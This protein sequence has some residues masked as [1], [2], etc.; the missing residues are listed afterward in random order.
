M[1][2]EKYDRVIA[3]AGNPNVGKSSLFNELTGLRQ[4]TG[5]WTGKTVDTAFGECKREGKCYKIIDLPG[6]Y[7]LFS[8]SPEEE[9]TRRYIMSGEAELC[10]VVCDASSL[11]AGLPLVLQMSEVYDKLIVVLNL[12]DETEKYSVAIDVER[13]SEIL[14]CPVVTT[15]AKRKEGIDELISR[16]EEDIHTRASVR[17]DEDIEYA[18]S[19]MGDDLSRFE[20]I[21]I[22]CS[23]SIEKERFIH[24][25]E[26]LYAAGLYPEKCAETVSGAVISRAQEIASECVTKSEKQIDRNHRIDKIVTGKYTAVPIMLL[27]LTAVLFLTVIGANYPSRWLSSFFIYAEGRLNELL[28]LLNLPVFIREM[29]VCGMFRVCGW[30]ISVMLAPMAIFF[31]LFTLLEDIGILPRIA[32]NMDGCFRCSGSCGK[33][34]LTMCMG[35]GCNAVGVCGCRIID[36]PRDRMIAILTNVFVPCNGRFPM[37]LTLISAFLVFGVSMGYSSLLSS[38]ILSLFIIFGI[39]ITFGVSLLLSKSILRGIPS[40]F[41]L[42]LVPYR[43]PN[44]T[45]VLVRSFL[46]RTVFVLGRAVSVALPAGMVIWLIANLSVNDISLLKYI[47]DFFDPF[48]RLFG[49]DGII[50]L[51]FILGLPANEIVLPI[52]IMGYT[53]A[54][55]LAE[56]ESITQLRQL[57]VSCGWDDLRCICV[58]VFC[59]CHFP[60]ST[61]LL[62]IKRETGSLRW[63]LAAFIIPTLTGLLICFIINGI[64]SLF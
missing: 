29:I 34:S 12:W 1:N 62:S 50:L 27:L 8:H 59:I 15:S 28:I 9:V 45:K 40:S 48:A 23:K 26:Y 33:Q 7:S 2:N 60:C 25:K 39:F 5:N 43:T 6:T 55:T 41:T 13:L 44:I 14:S 17:Y 47:S 10:C 38:L 42:E 22:I 53:G 36:S 30:V 19:L 35:F 24:A 57:L 52:M 32:F 49:L 18:L 54:G 64:G 63:T 21:R 46:D 16:F 56:Y 3:L 37:L 20:K 61:T 51:G 11:E 4:H 58:A 31:P